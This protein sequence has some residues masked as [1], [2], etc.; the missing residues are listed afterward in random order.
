MFTDALAVAAADHVHET[1]PRVL[2]ERSD[3]DLQRLLEASAMAN[4][5]CGSSGLGLVHALSSA[6]RLRV[7]HGRAN[8]VLLPWVA[9]FNRESLSPRARAE[10]ERI[11]PLYEQIGFEPS[12]RPGELAEEDVASVIRVALASPLH[13]NNCRQASAGELEEILSSAGM[14][15]AVGDRDA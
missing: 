7:A 8:G 3:D 1:L 9:A 12:L 5:A 15:A 6:T 13:H 10:A 4:L 14:R 2:D 11:M